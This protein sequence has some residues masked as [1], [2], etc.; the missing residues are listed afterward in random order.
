MNLMHEVASVATLQG[1]GSI[2]VRLVDVSVGR[3]SFVSSEKLE[4]GPSD[5]L[6][7]RFT[8]PGDPRLHFAMVQL[9]GAVT[10]EPTAT[11]YEAEFVRTDPKTVDH[12]MAFLDSSGTGKDRSQ[13]SVAF[14]TP[15]ANIGS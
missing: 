5:Q 13:Y 4:S 12:I 14:Q 15:S 2:S 11:S 7:M 3:I 10:H 8:L 6:S 1:S 9:S